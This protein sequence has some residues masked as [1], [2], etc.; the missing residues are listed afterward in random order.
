MK[1]KIE[2]SAFLA[3]L[4]ALN[5]QE[6]VNVS[7][8]EVAA[9][10]DDSLGVTQRKKVISA[11]AHDPELLSVV[12]STYS[13]LKEFNA[14][15]SQSINTQSSSFVSWF[16]RRWLSSGAVGGLITAVFAYFIAV[17][18]VHI[19]QLDSQLS[20][21]FQIAV[22]TPSS[23]YK[24]YP[25]S[26][27]LN[28]SPL[29]AIEE[30]FQYGYHQ[31]LSKLDFEENRNTI[32]NCNSERTCQKVKTQQ[33]LGEWTGLTLAQCSSE[34]SV[35]TEFWENQKNILN[36][37]MTNINNEKIKSFYSKLNSESSICN[38]AIQFNDILNQS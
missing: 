19:N 31:A 35:S 33:L 8:E 24:E 32:P 3:A 34:Y 11:F 5:V 22:V 18:V 6:K 14:K 7:D 17:P 26:K 23:F 16:K 10:L 21:N 12:V 2:G 29:T 4:S 1:D 15:E 20:D 27:G 28:S 9:F 38:V 30:N 25:V 36:G 13:A 37:L